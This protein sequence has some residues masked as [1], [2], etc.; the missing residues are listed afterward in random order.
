[1]AGSYCVACG[2]FTLFRTV[3]DI[4]ECKCGYRDS[5]PGRLQRP[6]SYLGPQYPVDEDPLEFVRRSVLEADVQRKRR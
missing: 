6:K 4:R 3:G 1:M 5:K 2:G